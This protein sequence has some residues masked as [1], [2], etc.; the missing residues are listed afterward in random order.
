MNDLKVA[1]IGGSGVYN[2]FPESQEKSIET[3]YGE[4]SD[5]ILIGKLG[6]KRVAFIP[7]HGK[8]HT[9]PP[10]AI[11][12]R[13]NIH[14]LASLYVQY[15]IGTA[16]VGVINEKIKPVYFIIPDGFLDFTGRPWTFYDEFDEGK[17]PFHV[18]MTYPFSRNI[19]VY[20]IESCRELD[21]PYH[22][23]GVYVN[24]IGPRF[25]NPAEIEMYLRAGADIVGMT[26]VPE[27]ILSSE[28]GIYYATIAIGTNYAAGISKNPLR[29]DEVKEMMVEREDQLN[30]I[31]IRT[32]AKLY[33][34]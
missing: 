23:G 7:R 12:H 21:F 33:E 30:E 10:H 25:E 17:G 20:L 8:N 14:A 9:I 32:V 4:P 3:P 19:R 16:A 28:L 13:A 24:T 22:D 11:N 31:L 2:L 34:K 15:L 1:I 6:D 5:S 26:N 18:D 27:V 29:Y